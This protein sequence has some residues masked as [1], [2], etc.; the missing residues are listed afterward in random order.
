MM[1][2]ITRNTSEPVDVD[3]VENLTVDDLDP[4][5]VIGLLNAHER[6][7]T[8]SISDTEVRIFGRSG[9]AGDG[10]IAFDEL[11]LEVNRI[12]P[13]RVISFNLAIEDFEDGFLDP[14]THSGPTTGA[15]LL[16]HTLTRIGEAANDALADVHRLV[17]GGA[18]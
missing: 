13:G 9:I 8:A 16:E 11:L 3:D 14:D 5:F 2:Q 18:A 10:S 17:D 12:E 4:T 6:A 7:F 15:A 1:L